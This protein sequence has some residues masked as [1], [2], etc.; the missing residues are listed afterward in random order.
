MRTLISGER[1]RVLLAARV[2]HRAVGQAGG[3]GN[4]ALR[5]CMVR[6]SVAGATDVWRRAAQVGCTACLQA[7]QHTEVAHRTEGAECS[8]ARHADGDSEQRAAVKTAGK[9]YPHW[10]A[11]L[12]RALQLHLLLPV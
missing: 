4:G 6:W 12:L 3:V 11:Y 5:A 1:E 9:S 8:A 2:K 7:E 10:A